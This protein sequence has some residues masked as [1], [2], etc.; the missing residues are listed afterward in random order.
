MLYHRI[1]CRYEC[2]TDRCGYESPATEQLYDADAKKFPS[3]NTGQTRRIYIKR[4]AQLPTAIGAHSPHQ[5]K[6]HKKER[7]NGMTVIKATAKKSASSEEKALPIGRDSEKTNGT[8]SELERIMPLSPIMR[9]NTAGYSEV[10]VG[11]PE[12]KT[13][14]P[15]EQAETKPAISAAETA[16]DEAGTG[17]HKILTK[18]GSV[19]INKRSVAV[20]ASLALICGALVVNYALGGGSNIAAEAGGAPPA[21]A[22]ADA[23]K[24]NIEKTGSGAAAGDTDAEYFQSASVSRRRARD[25]SLEVLQLVADSEDA[26]QESKDS[27]LASIS[28]IASQI[29]QESNIESL[30]V[31]KGFENCIALVSDDSATIIV[32]SDGLMP[33]EVAQITEIICSETSLPAASVKIVE[34]AGA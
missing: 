8:L 20:I 23:D 9:K 17:K 22:A 16:S 34:K 21:E 29:E 3:S 10:K 12:E 6:T 26:L 7:N 33:N 30:I 13:E 14:A 11:L 28:K 15:A 1:F 27:A 25:E 4:T 18:L 32:Q 2:R 31:A 24:D 5:T 19:G